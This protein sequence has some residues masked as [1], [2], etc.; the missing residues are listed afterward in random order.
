MT[1]KI[2]MLTK[3]ASPF[4]GKELDPETGLY[5]YGA[6]YLD[7]RTGRWL[8]GDPAMGDYIPGAPEN[9][10]ARKRNG[11]LP[12]MGGVFN[13]VNLHTY[14]YAGNNPVKYTDPDGER[15]LF[16]WEK[17]SIAT[18]L[19]KGHNSTLNKVDFKNTRATRQQ[20]EEGGAGCHSFSA[21]DID[22]MFANKPDIGESGIS[23]PNGSIY[24]P[25]DARGS[26]QAM[27]ALLIH[28]VFHQLQYNSNRS[29]T[30]QSLVGEMM[31]PND[32]YSYDLQSVSTLQNMPTFESQE[33]LIEDFANGYY[34][35]KRFFGKDRFDTE[36]IQLAQI[37]KDSGINSS[38]VNRVLDSQ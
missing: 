2:S 13:A 38:A 8:S 19:G 9:E 34:E 11:N 27:K 29:D 36:T 3:C 14:H 17:I 31:S 22:S 26:R 18:I 20:I 4:T 15:S 7:P 10:E 16:F 5:Y 28:E 33:K 6:R 32:P 12:G 25:K 30:I 24:I 35:G 23:L 21:N 37:M 1:S